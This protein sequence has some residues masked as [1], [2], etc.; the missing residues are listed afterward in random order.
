[1]TRLP[2]L[3]AV[4]LAAVGAFLIIVL[5]L[6]FLA[7]RLVGSQS[8]E[9]AKSVSDVRVS[10]IQ[11]LGGIGLIGGLLYTVRTFAL[12]RQTHRAERFSDAITLI[13]NPDS[14]SVRSGGI[15]TL[16]LLVREDS[17]YWAPTEEILCGF[18][19][20][21]SMA[22]RT[23]PP[24]VIAA[25][26]V[27]G[28]RKGRQHAKG[29]ALHLQGLHLDGVSLIGLDLSRALLSNSH[30]NN[31]DLTDATLDGTQFD[32]ARL[33]GAVFAGAKAKGANFTAADLT[34]TDFLGAD[35]TSADL[36]R[37]KTTRAKNLRK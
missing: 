33:R 30:L 3:V 18:A 22:G 28:S 23:V 2:L 7:V 27:L 24:D 6:Q 14:S 16:Q 15:Y 21:R 11:L 37:A 29:R 35:T 10:L 1:M 13:G 25:L 31:A 19:S 32:G 9:M 36:S 26:R 34:D 20:E 4:L 12:S 17:S 5:G 8:P